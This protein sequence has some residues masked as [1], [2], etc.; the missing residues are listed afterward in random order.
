MRGRYVRL[1]L[2][3]ATAGEPE[4]PSPMDAGL[5]LCDVLAGRPMRELPEGGDYRDSGGHGRP[6]YSGLVAYAVVSAVQLA[7][8][9]SGDQDVADYL[10]YLAAGHPPLGAPR[11]LRRPEVLEWP[12]AVGIAAD[13]AADVAADLWD[14][15]ATWRSQSLTG[16]T[17]RVPEILAHVVAAQRP[18]GAYFR[19][20][21]G[22]NPEP[23]WYHELV[24]LHA[25]TS[26]ELLS[27]GRMRLPGARHAAAFH[28]AETQPDHA[29]GQPWAVHAFLLDLDTTPTADLLLLAAG[30]NGAGGLSAVSR[31]LLADAAVCA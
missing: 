6:F 30:V 3:A 27:G 19:F 17:V 23:W 7:F 25:V 15:L 1:L 2:H 31:I 18:D 21:A 16:E 28:H 10:P 24:A 14:A 22:D 29:T 4:R 13:A 5:V 11:P 9:A 20:D 8:G 26:F 12:P